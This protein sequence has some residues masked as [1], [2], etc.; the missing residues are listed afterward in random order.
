MT[1]LA[2]KAF[3]DS[4]TRLFHYVNDF[5]AL[6]TIISI[7]SVVLETV[8]SLQTYSQI[9]FIIEWVAVLL[10]TVEYVGRTI[11]SKPIWKYPT[12]FF[13]YV[14]LVSIVPTF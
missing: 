2:H 6:L 1:S 14:D 12:S 4:S 7:V 5:F 8:P 10:F 11:A 13:G 9:F 3:T